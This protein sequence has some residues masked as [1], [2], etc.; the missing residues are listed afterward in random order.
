[1]SLFAA[2]VYAQAL[3]DVAPGT[4]QPPDTRRSLDLPIAQWLVQGEKSEIPWKLTLP[5]AEPTFRLIN[6]LTITAEVNADALERR[7]IGHDLRFIIKVAHEKGEWDDGES[8]SNFHIEQALSGKLRMRAGVYLKP[9][10]YTIATIL[11]D[12]TTERRNLSFHQ[13]RVNGSHSGQVPE[14]L[15]QAPEISFVGSFTNLGPLGPRRTPFPVETQRAVLFDLMVDLSTREES[16]ERLELTPP[17]MGA[18]GAGLPPT[19]DPDTRRPSA[20]RPPGRRERTGFA[21]E[22]TAEQFK[23]QEIA[24]TL[25]R[26][27]FQPG[28]VRV[29][30]L[31]VLR[32]R[33][34]VAPTPAAEVDWQQLGNENSNVDKVVVSVA[35]LAGR[36]EAGVFLKDQIGQMIA[37]PPECKLSSPNPLH[38]IAILSHGIHFPSGSKKPRI[39]P[40]CDCRFFYFHETDQDINGGDELGKMIEPLA[41]RVLQFGSPEKFGERMFEFAEAVKKIP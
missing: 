20:N 41:P 31:D 3:P 19:P 29:T 15:S 38:I 36:R 10:A 7:G 6:L 28:C 5:K 26:V 30:A 14:L 18:G 17:N 32:L 2:P 9:G 23:L 8:D 34:L 24:K 39:E 33:T 27:D 37:Q 35:N 12:A 40:A 4:Q 16:G 1:M 22:Q 11:Y 13:V 25:A 21:A